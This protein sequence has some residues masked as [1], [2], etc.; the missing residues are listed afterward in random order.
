MPKVSIIVPIYNVEKYLGKCVD[1][2]LAQTF[3]DYE[4]FLV[5]D[6]SPDNCGAICDRYAEKDGRIK[7]IHKEN[8]GLSDARNVAIDVASGEY[9]SFIDSDDYIDPDMIASMYDALIDTDSDMAVCGMESFDDEGNISDM[10]KPHDRRMVFEGEA[11]CE[12]LYQPCAMNKFY[13]RSIF[14][15]LRYPKG[16]LYEDAVIF[17]YI[18]EKS[19]KIVYTGKMSYHYFLRSG[20]IMRSKYT[21]RSA[22]VVDAVY[23]RAVNL[24]RM[25]YFKD[26]N[27]ASMAV[28]TRTALAFKKLD[29]RIPENKKRLK[30]LKILVKKRFPAL[31]KYKGNSLYQKMRI[32]VFMAFPILH[33]K[34]LVKSE[35]N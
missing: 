20:S 24:E 6:G 22:D 13:K 7:V 16:R 28:Y 31:M 26:A 12:F 3:T 14:D 11:R 5:D 33:G 8:G 10:Y 30:Q 2:I 15:D 35:S 29:R 34:L 19:K 23:D 18:L 1:S 32:I 21:I 9:L 27:E 17:H 4:L 25:G